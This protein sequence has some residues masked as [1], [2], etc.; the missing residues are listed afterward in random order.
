MALTLLSILIAALSVA[1]C[2]PTAYQD[3]A[4]TNSEYC[5][6]GFDSFFSELS[7]FALVILSS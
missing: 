5:Y 1:Y 7:V 2:Y 6:F 4:K 3:L